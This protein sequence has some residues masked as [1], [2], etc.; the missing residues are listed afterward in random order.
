MLYA[1]L[2]DSAAASAAMKPQA[3]VDSTGD[4]YVF[5]ELM[6]AG[7]SGRRVPKAMLDAFPRD[8]LSL[9]AIMS[10]GADAEYGVSPNM[11]LAD[12]LSVRAN[13]AGTS[14]P[15]LERQFAWNT[16]RPSRAGAMRKEAGTP[17]SMS[18]DVLSAL[19]WDGDSVVA[20]RDRAWRVVACASE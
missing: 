4:N 1:A 6:A 3:W 19:T 17:K 9:M 5:T 12:S 8:Q 14:V 10:S 7:S 15:Y 2:K 16:G 18:D 11:A 13:R 20:Q